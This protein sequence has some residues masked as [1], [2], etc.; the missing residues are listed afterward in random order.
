MKYSPI[1]RGTPEKTI[2]QTV[3]SIDSKVSTFA[4]NTRHPN[5]KDSCL[6]F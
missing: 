4:F 6:L 2:G 3:K 1:V 5:G